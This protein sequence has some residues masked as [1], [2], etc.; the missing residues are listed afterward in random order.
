[1]G[2]VLTNNTALAFAVESAL[3]VV[4]SDAAWRG[5]E[6]N[7]Y[8]TLGATIT[9]VARSPISRDRQRRKGTITD[10]DSAV[11]FETDLILDHFIGFAE[12]FM[13]A[14]FVGA[15]T[16][17]P[18]AATSGG[19]GGFTVAEGGDLTEDTLVYAKGFAI[20]ANNGLHVVASGASGTNIRVDGLTA[21]TAPET[22]VVEVCGVRGASGDIAINASGNLAS[23]V[24]DF[25]SLPLH[26]GMF[27][28]I[29]SDDAANKFSTAA[30]Y[31][32]A[33][34][35]SIAAHEIVLDR[36]GQAY[37]ADTGTGK[38]V[39]ILY[40][41]F[42]RNVPVGDADFLERSF[43][44]EAAYPG[45][46]DADETEYEYARGNYCNTLA[47]GI[48]LTNKST[49]TYAFVGLDTDVPTTSRKA[50][51][52]NAATPIQ[53]A[54]FNTS[55]DIAR[56]II[57]D[58]DEV[59][60]TSDFKSLT[61]NLNNNVTPEKVIGRLGARYM[62][63]GN[64][65]VSM[66]ATLLFTSGAVV[67]AIRN[68]TQLGMDFV[69]RNDDGALVIDVPSLTL[70]GGGKEFPVN[71]SVTINTT[72]QAYADDVLGYSLGMSLFPYTP[73][74]A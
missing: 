19:S 71:E 70:G 5:V 2:R 66:D 27:I 67:E 44:F 11:A 14:K 42:L 4:A 13:F 33:R 68:N 58:V 50:G 25:T 23:S 56:L 59:G 32:F 1:M 3:G 39:D 20:E 62:N 16:F 60:L 26:P 51:A 6:P 63:Y 74:L 22:A 69:L 38:Q 35:V 53:S 64:F 61:V 36:R 7:S 40:G 48:P 34:I 12:G 43:M 54:A 47:F 41:R 37:S 29:G 8:N 10:L 57:M 28:H 45:L 24:L 46:G 55:A 65:E 31:G 72:V 18:T 17:S 9:T 73:A 30:D 49:M 15:P 21:E 52:D